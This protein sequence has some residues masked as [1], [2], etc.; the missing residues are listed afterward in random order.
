MTKKKKKNEPT[1]QRKLFGKNKKPSGIIPAIMM[2]NP[3]YPHNVGA[4]VRAASCF[5]FKQVW[6]SGNRIS[7][8]PEKGQRLPR[9]ERM[10]GYKKVE[11]RQ[12]DYIF[13]EFPK[14]V[15]VAVEL[16]PNAVNLIEFEHPENPLYVFGPEDG[17]LS[18]QSRSF[19]H[20]FVF[21]PTCYC[22]NLSAAIY[23]MMYDRLRKRV[24]AGLEP[25]LHI[26]QLIQDE[27]VW[28]DKQ[29]DID[30]VLGNAK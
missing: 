11:L 22:T 8:D 28:A 14:A 15:P 3:K 6:F 24:E 13:D 4:A 10:R 23:L 18:S 2:E 25:M 21:I 29:D 5:R 26:S 17:H 30:L 1:F 19:C 7:L 9:E 12:H 20:H 27:R 16:Q